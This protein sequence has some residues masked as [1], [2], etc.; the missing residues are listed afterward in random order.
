MTGYVCNYAPLRF[1]PY[2]ETGEFVN[3]GVVLSCPQTGYF[4]FKLETRKRRR[5]TDFFPEL[6]PSLLRAALLGMMKELRILAARHNAVEENNRLTLP[7]KNVMDCFV[8]LVRRREGIIYFGTVG[9]VISEDPKQALV[10]LFGKFVERQF[11]QTREYQET[12]MRHR[13]AAS[14]REWRI[15]RQYA[16]NQKVG[17]EDFKVVMPFVHFEGS[18]PARAIKP[19]DLDKAEPSDI[20]HHGGAWVKDM[21]RLRMRGHMPAE[22]VFTLRLPASG[23]RLTAAT[24]VQQ[25]LNAVG[26]ITVDFADTQGVRAVVERGLDLD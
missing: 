11:A 15:A 17:D 7:E 5:I 18:N 8:H 25:E 24:A 6:D 1:L 10:D 14:L 2:R 9:M 23:K 3:V 22:T 21:E 13:L 20:Y 12:V 26:V 4:G 16:T 19:L